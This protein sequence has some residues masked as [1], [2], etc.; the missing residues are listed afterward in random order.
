M[1]RILTL[2]LIFSL[3][4]TF[5]FAQIRIEKRRYNKGWYVSLNHKK[6]SSDEKPAVKTK[7]AT[8]KKM[9]AEPVSVADEKPL[10]ELQPVSETKNLPIV[11][12]PKKE[13]QQK[14]TTKKPAE[15]MKSVAA[16]AAEQIKKA[17]AGPV[18]MQQS[19]ARNAKSKSAVKADPGDSFVGY[20]FDS[21]RPM[22]VT[23]GIILL[24]AAAGLLIYGLIVNPVATLLTLLTILIYPIIYI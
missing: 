22:F 1:K 20:L 18:K 8:E 11:S 3:I 16:P 23:I 19:F 10:A 17:V 4:S 5:S 9:Q 2:S 6:N 12:E 7:P 24:V 15:K 21:L 14:Q 13:N